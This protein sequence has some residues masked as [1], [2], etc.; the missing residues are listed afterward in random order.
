M[1]VTSQVECGYRAD[2]SSL[3]RQGENTID[4]AS[5]TESER[6]LIDALEKERLVTVT[7]DD[8]AAPESGTKLSAG[9]VE[10]DD[11][12]EPIVAPKAPVTASAARKGG[13]R[14]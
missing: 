5:L 4:T 9:P 12:F 7:V 11:D 3:L 14:R 6:M 1:K 10:V 8:R 2:G 13:R